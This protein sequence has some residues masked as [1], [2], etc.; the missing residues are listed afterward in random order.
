M[1]PGPRCLT[2]LSAV[3]VKWGLRRPYQQ[4]LQSSDAGR[5][6]TKCIND[7][8]SLKAKSGH[9]CTLGEGPGFLSNPA[10]FT[11]GDVGLRN[12]SVPTVTIPQGHVRG[13]CL[14]AASEALVLHTR[15]LIQQGTNSPIRR[16]WELLF[17]HV[18]KHRQRQ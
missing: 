10:A 4:Q 1:G 8:G 5:N 18:A 16:D 7:K 14:G 15:V 6:I 9:W 12:V 13:L 2:S 3:P 17:L 11:D